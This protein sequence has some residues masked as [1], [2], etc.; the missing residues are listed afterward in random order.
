MQP[1]LAVAERDAKAGETGQSLLEAQAQIK[2]LEAGQQALKE[3]L[4]ACEQELQALRQPREPPPPPLA[5]VPITDP[6]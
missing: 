1:E 4:V 3:M 6:P 5:G 2:S